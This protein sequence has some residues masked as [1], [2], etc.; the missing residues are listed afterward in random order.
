MT[1]YDIETV[2]QTILANSDFEETGS[3]SKAKAFVTAVTR[4]MILSPESSSNQSSSLSWSK[5]QINVLL[6]SARAYIAAND[7]SNGT[8]VRHLGVSQDFKG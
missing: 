2:A 3:L 6:Q 1:T 7:S 8:S 5:Q 4:W